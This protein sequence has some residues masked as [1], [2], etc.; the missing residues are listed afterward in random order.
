MRNKHLVVWGVLL[1]V[2]SCAS[3]EPP[4]VENGFYINPEY[5]F[6]FRIPDGWEMAEGLPEIIKNN[7]PLSGLIANPQDS[8]IKVTC[9]DLKNNRF[10]LVVAKETNIDWTLFE[11][12]P[13]IISNSLDEEFARLKREHLKRSGVYDIS[14]E[15]YKGK[16]QNCDGKCKAIKMDFRVQ[17]FMGTAYGIF[18][19]SKYWNTYI[20]F[21][22]YVTPDELNTPSLM[23]F[24]KVVDSFQHR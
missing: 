23:V 5:N 6:S 14:Y 7:I 20:C 13:V 24:E 12:Y 22:F 17:D 3:V 10:I 16:I 9:S 19:I 11:T 1:I 15:I 18:Y 21:L 2:I 8:S 4:R